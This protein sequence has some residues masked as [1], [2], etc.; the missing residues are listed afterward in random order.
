MLT[1]PLYVRCRV[2]IEVCYTSLYDQYRLSYLYAGTQISHI[3]YELM[4]QQSPRERRSFTNIRQTNPTDTQSSTLHNKPSSIRH[5][6]P[7]YDRLYSTLLV[8][9]PYHHKNLY[10]CGDSVSSDTRQPTNPKNTKAPFTR[11]P[12]LSLSL[13]PFL[14]DHTQHCCYQ[15][16]TA[17]HK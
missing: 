7:S 9:N 17:T 10:M 2:S 16:S 14:A 15:A 11:S 8:P 6:K 5:H 12:N 3:T 4:H 1:R 13:S